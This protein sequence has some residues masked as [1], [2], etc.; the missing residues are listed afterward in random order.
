MGRYDGL[1]HVSDWLP[2]FVN[3]GGGNA[4][5]VVGLDGHDVWAAI[6]SGAPSPRKEL[7]H[8]IDLCVTTPPPVALYSFTCYERSL[9]LHPVTLANHRKMYG[10]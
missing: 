3:L 8:N 9:F 1:V 2:S 5:A 10:N 6:A 4:S 7:L